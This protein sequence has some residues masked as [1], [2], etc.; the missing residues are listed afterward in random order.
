VQVHISRKK[1]RLAMDKTRKKGFSLLELLVTLGIISILISLTLPAIQAAREAGR[2]ALCS[3]N[4]R[5]IGLAIHNYES[6]HRQIPF[7][8]NRIGAKEVGWGYGIL[9]YLE[10]QAFFNEVSNGSFQDRTI[11][12]LKCPTSPENGGNVA[13]SSYHP[14]LGMHQAFV[15]YIA[16][17]P[18]SGMVIGTEVKGVFS[19]NIRKFADISDG[20]SNT[21]LIVE[22]DGAPTYWHK[23]HIDTG[24]VVGASS[25]DP[26]SAFM[27]CGVD[28]NTGNSPGSI[29][30]GLT[31]GNRMYSDLKK[32]IYSFHSNQ[33]LTLRVDGSVHHI[34]FHTYTPIIMGLV[35]INDGLSTNE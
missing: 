24:S 1:K 29:W 25:L 8:K 2:K 6:A 15:D 4:L 30:G 28:Y 16:S 12:V 7:V 3:N 17:N 21:L 22:A 10:Q 23:R 27:I 9:P 11:S 35:G 18:S 20:L 33:F 19:E 26:E 31:N 14:P 5:Q 32:E 13:F 34:S